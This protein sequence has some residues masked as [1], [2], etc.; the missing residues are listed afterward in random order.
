MNT[1]SCPFCDIDPERIV[2]RSR[3]AYSVADIYP[4]SEGHTLVIP[5]RHVA[6]VFNLPEEEQADL[7]RVVTQVR[8]DLAEQHQPDGFNIGV[9]DGRSAGQT[10][11]HAHVHVIPRYQGDVPDPRGGIRWVLGGKAPYWKGP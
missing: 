8:K 10:V 6:S 1:E 4:V 9:N 3:H 7:W 2:R 11:M 5:V